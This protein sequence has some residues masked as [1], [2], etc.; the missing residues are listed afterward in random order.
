MMIDRQ[1]PQN[2]L[3][4]LMAAAITVSGC[5]QPVAP[6][7]QKGLPEACSTPQAELLRP[8]SLARD[9]VGIY[10]GVIVVNQAGEALDLAVR[11]V[12]LDR[13]NREVSLGLNF[14]PDTQNITY[15]FAGS[16]KRPDATDQISGFIEHA[17]VYLLFRYCQEQYRSFGRVRFSTISVADELAEVIRRN[18]RVYPSEDRFWRD[19]LE[20]Q[21]AL[22]YVA[23]TKEN[24]AELDK[25]PL[26]TPSLS[27]YERRVI[28]Q[29]GSPFSIVRLNADYVSRFLVNGTI[30]L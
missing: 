12:I 27:T 3:S 7:K 13:I 11:P 22:A 6:E 8:P 28:T 9:A 15:L 24:T 29:I 25:I 5:G 16:F 18:P 26:D 23:R 1:K 2:L 4:I 19:A 17:R 21:L 20:V 10:S 30:S 14:T